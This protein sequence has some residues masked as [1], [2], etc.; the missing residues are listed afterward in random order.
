V[1]YLS[2]AQLKLYLDNWYK[3]VQ[4]ANEYMQI[5]Q[6]WTK[7]KDDARREEGIKDLQFL[8]WVVKQLAVL[9]APILVDGFTKMQ[10]ILGN[11][12]ISTLDSS[13]HS[14]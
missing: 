9:S 5:E 13:L 7:L 6:P 8:L 10:G 4:K 1:N 14:K 12:D 2:Q 11:K 3:T